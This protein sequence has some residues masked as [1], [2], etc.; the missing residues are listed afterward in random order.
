MKNARPAVVILLLLIALAATTNA[1]QKRQTTAKPQPKAAV[2]PTPAPT[3]DTLVPA[4]FY[5]LYG[6]VRGA[7]QLIRS[8]ALNDLLEPVLKLA[9]PA[10]EL[11]T[12]VKWLNAHAEEVMTS[13]LLLATWPNNKAKDL[14]ESM[15][16]IEFESAEEAAK[17]TISLSEFLPSVLPGYLPEP[18]AEKSIRLDITEKPKPPPT[19]KFHL[20]RFGSLVVITP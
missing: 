18:S 1:Q 12:M 20:K 4:D 17:F 6:E 7:G 19:P 5:I 3:F 11:K 9:G 15:V 16:A 13:R 14:P 2:A 8:S 10:K